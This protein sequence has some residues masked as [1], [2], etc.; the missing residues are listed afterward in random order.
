MKILHLGNLA[1]WPYVV[2]KKQR[3]LGYDSENVIHEY[4]DVDGLD[5]KLPHDRTIFKES[6]NTL[7]KIFKTLRFLFVEAP[8]YDIIHY[9]STCILPRE[10]YLFEGLFLKAVN[11]KTVITFGGGDARVVSEARRLNKFF[12]RKPDA[13]RDF[14]IKWRW[15][16]WN[17][18]VN[19]SLADPELNVTQYN[20]I[21]RKEI[22]PQPF[23][24]DRIP[25]D[26]EKSAN[27]VFMHIPTEPWVKGTDQIDRVMSEISAAKGVDYV[28]MRNLEQSEFYRQLSKCDV[29][30]DELKCGSHGMT[31]VEAMAM[32]K[33]VIS[34]IREDLLAEFPPELPIYNCNPENFSDRMWSLAENEEL[35]RELQAASAAYGQKYHD[36]EKVAAKCVEIYR[37][38]LENA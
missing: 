14:I 12:Y 10:L 6:D 26:T 29:Y 11:V 3:A 21:R 38:E 19:V 17:K 16:G 15:F 30:I 31:A 8:K 20:R 32:G 28:R 23:D 27:L 33:V 24:L 34:Y 5:R 7:K 13:F 37:S 2:A 4:R 18:L 35:I 25:T 22:F 36:A 9:H 1:G